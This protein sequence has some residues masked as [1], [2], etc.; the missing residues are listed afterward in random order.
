ME[1]APLMRS[2]A[3]R[4]ARPF[5]VIAAATLLACGG[6]VVVD[7]D[8]HANGDQVSSAGSTTAT[9]GT[10]MG[11]A[12]GTTG[13]GGSGGAA[14]LDAGTDGPF[15]PPPVAVYAHSD[16]TLY[17]LDPGTKAVTVIGNFQGCSGM[18]DIA[19]DQ[20]GTIYGSG[21]GALF[22]V[23]P[24]TAACEFLAN[25]TY[26]NSLSFVP[27]GTLDPEKEALVGYL[28]DAYM[29]IDPETGITSKVGELGGGYASSGDLFSLIGGGTYLT[30]VNNGCSDCLVQVDP[31]TGKLSGMIGKLPYGQVW[32][33]AFWGGVA[34]GFTSGGL[35]FQIDPSSAATTLLPIP[36]A[37]PG[38]AFWGA[39]SSTAAMQ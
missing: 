33:L 23:D 28:G 39:G 3:R 14:E 32:G 35:L 25:G 8:P 20:V 5:L 22:R 9:T 7:G 6:K 34:F 37:P 24:K 18:I 13:S 21:S 11:G 16:T 30:V 10:G 26:P 12:G 17:L 27:K 38:L 29:R 4:L 15:P 31:A 2:L 36:N 1:Y 19:V